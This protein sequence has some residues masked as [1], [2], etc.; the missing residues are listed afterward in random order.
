MSQTLTYVIGSDRRALVDNIQDFKVDFGNDN[1]N[2]VQARQF[3][4]GMRQV[5][6]NV[7]NEDGTPP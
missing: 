3:E 1:N 2:W 7:V 5:F 4:R 6:V